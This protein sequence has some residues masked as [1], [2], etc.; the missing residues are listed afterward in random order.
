MSAEEIVSKSKESY[1]KQMC[2][3]C[4][5][6][7]SEANEAESEEVTEEVETEVKEPEALPFN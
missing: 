7:I 2:M 5:F 6:K 4:V 1:G 3:D